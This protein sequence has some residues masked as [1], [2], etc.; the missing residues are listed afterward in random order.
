MKM[1]NSKILYYL[2]WII[3]GALLLHYG[4]S[5]ISHYTEEAQKNYQLENTV[6]ITAI[7]PFVYGIY[8]ALLEGLPKAFV[9]N[10]L[11]LFIVFLPSFLLL[12]Y[13]TLVM[14]FNISN[15]EIFKFATIHDGIVFGLVSGMALVKSLTTN[16]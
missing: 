14:Y 12:M 16:R 8:L 11:L 5:L 13:P 15:M 7:V 4:N 10:W 9:V 3:V 1:R 6:W 2:V